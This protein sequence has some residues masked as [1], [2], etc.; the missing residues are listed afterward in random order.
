VTGGCELI[1]PV[2]ATV[3]IL[4]FSMS[5]QLT[6][7]AGSGAVRGPGFELIFIGLFQ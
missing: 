6:I 4:L 7:T 2:H 3:T 1:M 5:P